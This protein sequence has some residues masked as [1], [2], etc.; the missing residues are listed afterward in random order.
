MGQ[1]ISNWGVRT[2]SYGDLD[3]QADVRTR[4]STRLI[5]IDI[6]RGYAMLFML[7]SHSADDIPG[8]DYTT[9]FRWDMA[10]VPHLTSLA[11]WIGFIL[12]L[13]SPIF[14]LFA[15]FSLAFFVESR[16]QRKWDPKRITR[17]LMTRALVLIA[18]DQLVLKWQF[19]TFEY[20]HYFGVLFT[21]G[22]CIFIVSCL[23]RYKT[24]LIAI[25][26]FVI[27][28]AV[29]AYHYYNFQPAEPS[30]LHTT[31]LGYSG[32]IVPITDTTFPILA[33]LPVILFGFVCGRLL[34]EGHIRLQPF[35]WRAGVGLLLI[36]AVIRLF[37]G[38]GNYYTGNPLIFT[39]FP[40]DLAYF[41]FYLGWSFL[42]LW[43]H[44][45]FS[46]FNRTLY[47]NII[48]VFGQTALFFY[49]LHQKFILNI[50][51]RLAVALRV[52]DPVLTSFLSFTIAAVVLYFLCYR[53]RDLRRKYPDSV[54]KYF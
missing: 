36:W 3:N 25:L 37:G 27:L 13:S 48:L 31:L 4:V 19:T 41:T 50:T 28:I 47:A 53:Y 15:G 26:A 35:S 39:K 24:S 29:Q 32:D 23:W 49:T 10:N 22:S 14:F 46:N 38:F 43:A 11:D 2:V 20:Y 17:F 40:P 54:L 34:K 44:T 1:G 6:V 5:A 16:I 8:L 42:L 12:H 7:L 33:W 9:A 52:G 30:I 51:S 21:I 45:R 18:I